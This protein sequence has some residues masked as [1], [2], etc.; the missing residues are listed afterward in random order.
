MPGPVCS[1]ACSVDSPISQ[2]SGISARA[3]RTNSVVASVSSAYRATTA[4]G[5][6]ANDAQRIGRGKVR[7]A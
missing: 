7:L 4:A 1:A 5:A 3:E 2:A 6:R